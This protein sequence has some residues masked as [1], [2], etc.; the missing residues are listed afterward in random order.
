MAK[1]RRF[2]SPEQSAYARWLEL[3]VRIGLA[4]LLAIFVLYIIGYPAPHVPLDALPR[5]WG[6]PANRYLAAVGVRPGW[7]WLQFVSKGDY[8]NFVGISFLISVT[9]ICYLRVLPVMWRKGDMICAGL[10]LL[11]VAVLLFAASG[12]VAFAHK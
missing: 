12:V 1:V 8:L 11:Q 10:V 6:L 3:G 2:V 5:Y 4:G 9:A 7:G